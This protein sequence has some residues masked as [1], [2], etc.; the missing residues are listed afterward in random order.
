MANRLFPKICNAN[1]KARRDLI[2]SLQEPGTGAKAQLHKAL[3]Y[4][5][6]L[7]ENS[8]IG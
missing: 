6:E 5:I 2:D 8:L 4:E 3:M 7:I 1:L